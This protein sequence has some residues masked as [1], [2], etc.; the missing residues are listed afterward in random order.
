[1]ASNRFQGL[2]EV[3]SASDV[4]KSVIAAGLGEG[5]VGRIR[6]GLYTT[7]L[8]ESPEAVVKRNLWPVVSILCPSGVVSHRTAYEC[9]PTSHGLVVVTGPYDRKFAIPG[10]RIRQIKGPGPLAGDAPFLQGLYMSSRGRFLLECLSGKVYGEDSP[11]L[12]TEAVESYVERLLLLGDDKVNEARDLARKISADLNMQPEFA[13][14]ESIIGTLQGTRKSKLISKTA[15]ARASGNPY[16]SQ[17]NEIFQALFEELNTWP[18]TTR[19]DTDVAGPEFTNSGFF[20]MPISLISSKE[21]NSKLRRRWKL[22]SRTKSQ[23][24]AQRMPTTFLEPI[25]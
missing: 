23:P 20:A 9:R 22:L 1:M 3:F 17:R 25:E 13:R 2:L 19:K 4:N 8:K 24:R 11:F 16:D 5:K 21:L 14:L 6:R 7:N 12:S 15:I 18:A 10:L